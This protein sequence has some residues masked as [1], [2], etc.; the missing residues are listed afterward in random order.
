MVVIFYILILVIC[1]IFEK[2]NLVSWSL[3]GFKEEAGENN[4]KGLF[5]LFYC[6]ILIFF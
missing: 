4:M 2:R 1:F 3:L 5:R 6:L